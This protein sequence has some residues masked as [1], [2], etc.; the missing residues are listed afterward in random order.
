MLFCWWER[1]TKEHFVHFAG[2][3]KEE[4]DGRNSARGIHEILRTIRSC[5]G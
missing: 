1:F 4:L 5:R 2:I 3:V